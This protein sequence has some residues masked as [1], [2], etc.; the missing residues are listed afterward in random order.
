MSK[1]DRNGSTRI[2]SRNE[3][4]GFSRIM[5]KNDRNGSTR[6]MSKIGQIMVYSNGNVYNPTKTRMSK[7][8]QTLV[9]C[10]NDPFKTFFLAHLPSCL[11]LAKNILNIWLWILYFL[12]QYIYCTVL[13]YCTTNYI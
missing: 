2:M 1:N 5:S 8:R 13:P 3:I 6:I 7:N 10:L 4:N 12:A 9:Y 11:S